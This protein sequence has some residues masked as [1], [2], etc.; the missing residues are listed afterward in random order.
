MLQG[1]TCPVVAGSSTAHAHGVFSLA[2]VVSSLGTG[3][4]L[5][6]GLGLRV[7]FTI[8][9]AAILVLAVVVCAGT[10]LRPQV[11]GDAIPH[12]RARRRSRGAITAVPLMVVGIVGGVGIRDRECAPELG[13]SARYRRLRRLTPARL[14]CA[15]DLRRRRDAGPVRP[16][17][18]LAQSPDPAHAHRGCHRH[19]RQHRPCHRAGLRTAILGVALLAFTFTVLAAPI[20]RWSGRILNRATDQER[21]GDQRCAAS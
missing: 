12:S 17:A 19:D 8:T 9:A 14:P 2:V 21:P 16:G 20:S 7:T 15:G 5:A 4:L 18:A 13:L 6:Q 3:R 1:I 10:P 11:R